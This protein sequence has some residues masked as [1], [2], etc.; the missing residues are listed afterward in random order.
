MDMMGESCMSDEEKEEQGHPAT[1]F[2]LMLLD[3]VLS[4]L[5]YSQSSLGYL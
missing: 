3:A 4:Y 2:S 5:K 1:V